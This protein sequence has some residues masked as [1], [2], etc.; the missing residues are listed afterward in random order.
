MRYHDRWLAA[1]PSRT[2]AAANLAPAR[3]AAGKEVAAR[4][5]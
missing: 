1:L 5:G 4:L 2:R 3:A